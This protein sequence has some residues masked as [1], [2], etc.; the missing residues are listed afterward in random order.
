M[1][2]LKEKIVELN[3][4]GSQSD[5]V[6][7]QIH[8]LRALEESVIKLKKEIRVSKTSL[9]GDIHTMGYDRGLEKSIKLIDKY[10]VDY[11]KEKRVNK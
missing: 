11:K 8:A 9:S 6:I 4:R 10:L 3:G 1:K 7:M 2:S 5:G